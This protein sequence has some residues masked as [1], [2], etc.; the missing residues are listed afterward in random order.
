MMNVLIEVNNN[1]RHFYEG[2]S[3][4]YSR[5]TDDETLHFLNEVLN[6]GWSTPFGG[7][8]KEDFNLVKEAIRDE[9][10]RW[11]PNTEYISIEKIV[12]NHLLV[13]VSDY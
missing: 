11:F 2:L 9:V 4:F 1:T 5:P 3:P 8:T 12:G 13:Y 6:R 7:A 10:E